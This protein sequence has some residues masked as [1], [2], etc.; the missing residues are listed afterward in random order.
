MFSFIFPLG[1]HP[2]TADRFGYLLILLRRV[3]FKVLYKAGIEA[4]PRFCNVLAM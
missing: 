4:L 3:C 1:V 2:A